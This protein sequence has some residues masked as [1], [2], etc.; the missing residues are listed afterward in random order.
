M[1][2]RGPS[3]PAFVRNQVEVGPAGSGGVASSGVGFADSMREVIRSS[4][5]SVT[6]LA[7]AGLVASPPVIVAQTV[8]P[9]NGVDVYVA[10][11]TPPPSFGPSTLSVFIYAT[12]QGQTFLAGSGRVVLGVLSNDAAA[13]TQSL[14]V[15]VAS[16]RGL[17]DSWQ[18]TAVWAKNTGGTA[19]PGAVQFTVCASNDPAAIPENLGGVSF[20]AA[21]GL[22]FGASTA[23]GIAAAGTVPTTALELLN[24][25]AVNNGGAAR[26][27]HIHDV[28]TNTAVGV[29][30]LAPLFVLPLAAV[31]G[32]GLYLPLR[33]RA[34]QNLVII[35]SSTPLTTTVAADC[36]VSATVR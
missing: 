16:A 13:Q 9:W 28:G 25:Q 8:K 4:F 31:S 22:G 35:P 29:G 15:W 36:A 23:L 18:V 5:A 14:P 7:S 17:A 20:G 32:E 33:Y 11:P 2:L 6:A 24:V 30:G 12:S 3:L 27:L 10:L 19:P 34:R 26:F 1:T 21:I